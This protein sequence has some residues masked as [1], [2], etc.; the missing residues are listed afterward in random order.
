VAAFSGVDYIDI[1]IDG[2]SIPILLTGV[3]AKVSPPILSGHAVDAVNQIVLGAATMAQLGKHLGQ[4]VVVSLGSAS[5]GN[6]VIPPTKMLIVGTATLPAV[7]Y[8]SFVQQHTS[9][10]TGAIVP[11]GVEPAAAVKAMTNPDPNLNGP[12]LVFVRMKSGVSARAGWANMQDIANEANAVFAH[13]KNAVGNGVDVLGVQR[14]GQIVNYRSAGSTPIILAIG[15][16]LGAILALGLTLGSSVRR[17]R[18]DLALLKAFGFTQRQLTAAITWQ[19]TVDAVVG[20]LF[21]LPIGILLGRELWTLFAQSI[22]AVPDATVPVLSV[23]VVGLGALVF[24]NAVAV[25][26]GMTARRTSTALVLRAE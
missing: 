16:A 5:E 3:H 12:E 25:L 8:S 11:F 13:D 1:D 23:V 21:G 2:E 7:G 14:P 19:A 9:M 20:I 15:L 4:S 18:R 10:G 17:R 24:T 26:P 22:N 6:Q